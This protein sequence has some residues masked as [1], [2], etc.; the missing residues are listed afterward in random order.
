MSAMK[1]C[2]LVGE[3]ETYI[4]TLLELSDLHPG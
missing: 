3:V 4:R 1:G 2:R